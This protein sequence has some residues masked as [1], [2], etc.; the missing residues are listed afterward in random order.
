ML[1]D[2]AGARHSRRSEHDNI[3]IQVPWYICQDSKQSNGYLRRLKDGGSWKG[4]T[5]FNRKLM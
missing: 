2:V 4:K 1:L 3:M 5:C